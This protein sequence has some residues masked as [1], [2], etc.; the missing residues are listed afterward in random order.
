M[1]MLVSSSEAVRKIMGTSDDARTLR[2]KSNP[3]PSGRETSSTRSVYPPAAH[4]AP[5]SASVRAVSTTQPSFSSAKRS[6]TARLISSSSSSI[7]TIS[8]R[9][10]VKYLKTCV[11]VYY[12][13]LCAILQAPLYL[14]QN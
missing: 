9:P 12:N 5:P 13:L 6:P 14:D 10:P 7:F 11:S 8:P 1:M 2:Q 4:S 3:V